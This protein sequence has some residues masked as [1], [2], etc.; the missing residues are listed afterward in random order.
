[1]QATDCEVERR[2]AEKHSKLKLFKKVGLISAHGRLS[3]WR[4]FDDEL[5]PRVLAWE[6]F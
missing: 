1:M 5:N 4:S 3:L 2:V 6:V